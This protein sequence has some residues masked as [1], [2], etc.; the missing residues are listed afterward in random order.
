MLPIYVIENEGLAYE[1][2]HV[3][4]DIG[5]ELASGQTNAISYE[6]FIRT[7]VKTFVRKNMRKRGHYRE[8]C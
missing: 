3:V 6:A 5:V 2:W 1:A 4:R 8:A 7:F